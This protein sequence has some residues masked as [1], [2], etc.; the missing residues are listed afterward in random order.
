MKKNT[1]NGSGE[2]LYILGAVALST[3]MFWG[4]SLALQK[5]IGK[6]ADYKGTTY[7]LTSPAPLVPSVYEDDVIKIEFTDSWSMVGFSLKN[8]SNKLLRV[9]W[10]DSSFISTSKTVQKVAHAGIKYLS[11][12][13]PQPPTAIPPQTLLQDFVVPINN[14]SWDKNNVDPDKANWT[15]APLVSRPQDDIGKTI[16]LYLALDYDGVRVDKQFEF[17]VMAK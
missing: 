16:G 10:D 3:L 8:K 11:R 15:T 5:S 13:Q 2:I 1:E 17:T 12:D 14:I 4:S 7:K 6:P 9:L